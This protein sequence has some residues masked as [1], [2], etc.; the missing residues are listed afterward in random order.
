[1]TVSLKLIL[2]FVYPAFILSLNAIGFGRC[3]TRL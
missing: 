3:V 2:L 1:M